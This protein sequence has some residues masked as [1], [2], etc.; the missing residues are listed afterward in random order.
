MHNLKGY[1]ET[2]YES[3]KIEKYILIFDE[4]VFNLFQM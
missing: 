3:Y 4:H 2:Y 1:A